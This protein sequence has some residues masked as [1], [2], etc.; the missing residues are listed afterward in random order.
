M[1]EADYGLT[2]SA[3]LSGQQQARYAA[4]NTLLVR[5]FRKAKLNPRRTQEEG[6]PI[7]EETDYIEIRAPGNKSNVPIRPATQMDKDRF[8]EHWRKYEARMDEPHLEGTPL[9]HWPAINRSQ[10]EELRFFNIYTVEQLVEMPDSNAGRIMG[11]RM[12]QNQA[13]AFLEL[14]SGEAIKAKDEQI[15][16]M[17]EQLETMKAQLVEAG[18]IAPIEEDIVGE[19]ETDDAAEEETEDEAEVVEE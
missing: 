11:V 14:A 15:A 19:E 18:V 9:E 3:M 5:F 7:Y 16:S 4:D 12:L 1:L 17:A 10:V 2:E 8:P 13:K 6:R